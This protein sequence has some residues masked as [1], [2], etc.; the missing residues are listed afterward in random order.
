MSVVTVAQIKGY[1][2]DDYI[3]LKPDIEKYLE[4]IKTNPNKCLAFMGTG[5]MASAP[6]LHKL[7]EEVE[8]L[9]YVQI[10]TFFIS[11]TE[12]HEGYL[13]RSH[14]LKDII[15]LIPVSQ[16]PIEEPIMFVINTNIITDDLL[17]VIEN[18]LL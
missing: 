10:C 8:N 4:L 12:E 9:K 17:E 5:V 13:I 6:N 11:S 15:L 16:F 2:E 3:D 7:N 1:P 18:Q 14:P